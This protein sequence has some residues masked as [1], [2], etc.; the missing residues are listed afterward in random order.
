MRQYVSL[1]RSSPIMLLF[2]HNSILAPEMAAIRR[3]LNDA[4]LRA[5][6]ESGNEF[7]QLITFKVIRNGVFDAAMRLVTH[8]KPSETPGVDQETHYLSETAYQ[9]TQNKKHGLESLLAG[10]LAILTVPI[11]SSAHLTAALSILSPNPATP[12]PRKRVAP[13]LYELNTQAGLAKLMLLGARVEGRAMDV[14]GARWVAGLGDV[15]QVRGQ[16]VNV[17][18]GVGMSL[19]GGLEGNAKALWFALE[20]RRM[21]LEKEA[22]PKTEGD[23][24]KTEAPAS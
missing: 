12:A 8:W 5:D 22:A 23:E 7:S 11:S 14:D 15:E 16:L 4:L 20:G 21:E 24:A 6:K 1:L 9:A 19:V 10:P 18:Q 2:Q 17:L 13:G 3:E